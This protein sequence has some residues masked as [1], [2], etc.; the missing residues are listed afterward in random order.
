MKKTALLFVA[1][2]V[3]MAS[4]DFIWP[5]TTERTDGDVFEQCLNKRKEPF[6]IMNKLTDTPPK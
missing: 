1:V 5:F 3:S 4:I 6:S 2:L